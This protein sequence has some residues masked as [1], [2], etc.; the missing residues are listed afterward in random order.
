MSASQPNVL[1]IMTDQQRYDALGAHGNVVLRTPNLDALVAGGIDFT[2][3]YSTC[4]VCVPARYTLRS[5]HEPLG[6]GVTYNQAPPGLHARVRS[7][8][9]PWLAEVMAALGYR[10]WGVGKFHTVPWDADEGFEV[11]RYSEE[12]YLTP[13]QAAGDHYLRWL[14]T[15]HP[16]Y[17][18]VEQPHG[19]RTEMYY[20]PQVSPLPAALTVESWAADQ[21][22]E[23]V[24]VDDGRPFFGFVSFIG[25]HPPFAPPVPWNRAYDPDRMP[26][27]LGGDLAVDHADDYLPWM[28][29]AMWAEDVSRSEARALKARYYGELTYIDDCAGRILDALA[30]RRDADNTL[31]VFCTDHG[32]LLGDHHAWQK[33]SFFEASCHIPLVL[34]WPDRLAAGSRSDQLASLA[35]LFGVITT[36][37]GVTD[38][39]GGHDLL[40]AVS[41]PAEPRDVLLGVHGDPA[42]GEFKVMVRKG[43]WKLIHLGNGGRRQLFNLDHD[44]DELHDLD[45]VEGDV[46]AGLEKIAAAA[47]A[48]AGARAALDGDRLRAYP[49]RARPRIRIHQMD[50]SRGLAGF[51]A[52]PLLVPR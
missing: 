24:R 17:A 4:P 21:A 15:E 9:G 30:A 18:H 7:A 23:Q 10:T 51:P 6:H 42:S 22:C 5:G 25:P 3:A 29:H 31:V 32:E 33:D 11:L 45:A 16:E 47:L 43:P 38:L 12:L 34:R 41:G 39:R 50:L 14:R 8:T 46:A 44:R 2:E 49:F 40:G 37:A 48:D 26:D 1:V 13:A 20:V 27:A 36:A 28:N 35:D 19:E 52:D